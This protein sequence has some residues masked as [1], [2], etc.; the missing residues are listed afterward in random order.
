M[1]TS[2]EI[3]RGKLLSMA[4]AENPQTALDDAEII[5]EGVR[6]LATSKEGALPSGGFIVID[7]LVPNQL[8]ESGTGFTQQSVNRAIELLGKGLESKELRRFS[9]I[10]TRYLQNSLM[11]TQPLQSK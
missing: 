3:S 11:A 1:S 10:S 5:L 8:L 7:A 9:S 4:R 2:I 6:G